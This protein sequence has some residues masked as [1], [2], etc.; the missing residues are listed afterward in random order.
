MKYTLT[1][2]ETGLKNGKY[3]YKVTDETGKVWATRHSNRKYVACDKLGNWFF[4]RLDLIGKGAHAY[5]LKMC[6]E[7]GVEPL[8]LAYLEN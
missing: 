7:K 4:G 5:H 2:E 8:P 1:V 6:R 3:F